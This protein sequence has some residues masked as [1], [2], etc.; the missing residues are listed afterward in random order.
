MRCFL[1]V[2]LIWGSVYEDKALL[3]VF[4]GV[5]DLAPVMRAG[6]KPT[7]SKFLICFW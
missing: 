5:R 7:E 1:F 4:Y 6:V 3:I 2:S